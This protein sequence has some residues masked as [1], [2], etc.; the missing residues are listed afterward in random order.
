MSAWSQL[1]KALP[2]NKFFNLKMKKLNTDSLLQQTVFQGIFFDA[3]D[4]KALQMIADA[5]VPEIERLR[6]ASTASEPGTG[7]DQG[8]HISPSCQLFGRE[9]DEVNRTLVG[10]LSLKWIWNGNYDAFTSSQNKFVKLKPE[11]FEKV[12]KLFKDGLREKADL[13]NLLTSTI[14]NDLGKDPALA[15]DVSKITGLP[16]HAINHD[17]VIYEAAK[18]DIIPC[19]RRLDQ[20]HKE[21][22]FLGLRLGSTLNG[23]QLA[24]A[25]NVPGNLEGLLEMRGHRHAFD[26]KFLELI[27]DVA[28]A[29]GHIDSRCAKM[30]IEP[31][32]QAYLT[33][34]EVAL[35]IIEGRSS[36]REGYDTVLTRRAEMLVEKGFRMLSVKIPEER[37]LLRMLLMSRTAD[38]KQAELF[39][40][41]FDAL[42]LSIRRRLVNGLNVDGYQDGKAILPYYMPAMF[43]EALE[44]VS[45]EPL[46]AKIEAMSS[47]MRFLTRV[48]DGTRSMPG[49]EGKIVERNLMFARATIK[50]PEFKEDSTVLDKLKIPDEGQAAAMAS[51]E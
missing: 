43:S 49:K 50:S 51:E 28:G 12:H 26:L 16:P 9:Y 17:M 13:F 8:E 14:I 33:T 45:K 31:V 46:C 18:A 48:L 34:H 10:I 40:D 24:Q 1:W 15:E 35:D 3:D 20:T 30:M 11:T 21:E 32:A 39:S 36:L 41:A 42:P 25:E 38:A 29:A 27:L 7:D 47:L 37:A 2:R 5:F 22:L 19:I 44:N 4:A 23:G 6:N